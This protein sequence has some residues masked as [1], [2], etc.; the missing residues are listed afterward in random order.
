M[1][2][3]D[4]KTERCGASQLQ[5]IWQRPEQ[6]L[7]LAEEEDDDN[8]NDFIKFQMSI[9]VFLY[10][11]HLPSCILKISVW[12]TIH[13]FH[14]QRFIFKII[15]EIKCF[16]RNYF[17]PLIASALTTVLCSLTYTLSLIH[18][19]M[20]IRDRPHTSPSFRPIIP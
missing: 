6:C 19:Q 11:L 2:L 9:N 10:C 5:S 12:R 8:D 18:I 3:Q 4:E 14:V 20:C 13:D 1:E 15:Y 7:I 16:H 17:F